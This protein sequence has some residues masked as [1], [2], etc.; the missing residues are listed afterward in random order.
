M[1]DMLVQLLVIEL[2]GVRSQH[3]YRICSTIV[4]CYTDPVWQVAY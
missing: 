1:S 3:F 4:H 2:V